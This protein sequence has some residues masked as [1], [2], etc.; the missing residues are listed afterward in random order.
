M[1]T[2][3]TPIAE[4]SPPDAL[5]EELNDTTLITRFKD[6]E[7]HLFDGPQAPETLNEIG[8]VRE[9]EYR[10]MGAG[11]NLARDLDRLDLEEP[12]YRQIVSFDRSEGELVAMYRAQHGGYALRTGGVGVLR[13][14][15]LFEFSP[16]FREQELPHLIELGRSVVNSSSRRAI[17]GLFSIWSGLAALHRELPEIHGF[18]G[19]V[20]VYDDISDEQLDVLLSYLY[21]HHGDDAV[22]TPGAD[23]PGPASSARVV[24]KAQLRRPLKNPPEK[25][26]ADFEAL[27]ERAS[28]EGWQVPPILISYLK[29]GPGFTAFD[30]A[31][32]EDFGGVREIAV[33][34]PLDQIAPKTYARFIEP[35]VSTNPEAFRW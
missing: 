17:Q 9:L 4:A 14:S 18:F 1:S 26:P 5:R 8:R 11:R 32:D 15:T 3:M 24:A 30:T 35:Y 19:N 31:I 27:V 7:I 13:T 12:R 33:L 23:S 2:A 16:N 22:P 25:I 10:R 21:T 34:V 29:A 20:S 28:Q 6:L